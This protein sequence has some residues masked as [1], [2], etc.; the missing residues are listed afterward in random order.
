MNHIEDRAIG[1]STAR[2][3]GPG[4]VTG[5]APYAYEHRVADPV[6]LVP[7]TATI[8]RGAVR[9]IDTAAA[10]AVPGVLEVLTP[11]DAPR[12]TAEA[13]GE[14]VVLQSPEVAYR[15]QIV[16]AV[17]AETPEAARQACDQL[18]IEY[19]RQPHDAG[20]RDDHPAM[21][22]PEKVNGGYPADSERGN[23]DAAFDAADVVVDEWYST[24]EEHNNPLEPHTVVA[25]WEH[26][27]LTLYDSTQHPHGVVE[28]LAPVLGIDPSKIRVICPYIGGGF[29]SKG[30]PHAHDVLAAMAARTL[31]GRAVK[32][33]VSRQ[34]MFGYVGYRA[35]PHRMYASPPTATGPSG[36]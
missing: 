34:D 32:F 21:Y 23:V 26:D 19:D 10:L 5:T 4:K 29:G 7:A 22:A 18:A 27:E 17:I 16:A 20:F 33:A 15:G 36:D 13:E 9:N 35:R 1:T 14:Y 30:A 2:L 25:L 11:F 28:A 6:Y 8:A 31:P 3:D 24:P 12:L